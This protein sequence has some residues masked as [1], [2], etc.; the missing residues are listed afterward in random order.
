MRSCSI[1]SR[2]RFSRVPGCYLSCTAFSSTWP[3]VLSWVS[4]CRPHKHYNTEIFFSFFM[5]FSCCLCYLTFPKLNTSIAWRSPRSVSTF[6]LGFASPSPALIV[7]LSNSETSLSLTWLV[8]PLIGYAASLQTAVCVVMLVIILSASTYEYKLLFVAAVATLLDAGFIY[9]GLLW[10]DCLP[11]D[12][13][14]KLCWLNS[15]LK[16]IFKLFVR[17]LARSL[18]TVE[19]INKR[20]T[21]K[22]LASKFPA[23]NQ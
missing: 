20:L 12:F 8:N 17:L 14:Y 2:W 3:L 23:K 6:W 21:K 11:I 15:T 18:R 16:N 10:Y 5:Q 4:V 13:N 1:S 22:T 9:K 19:K 7:T